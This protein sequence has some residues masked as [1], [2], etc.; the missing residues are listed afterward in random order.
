MKEIEKQKTF[1]IVLLDGKSYNVKGHLIAVH[2]SRYL[3]Y[4]YEGNSPC[5]GLIVKAVLPVTAFVYQR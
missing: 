2:K 1:E 4:E 3:I 5:D